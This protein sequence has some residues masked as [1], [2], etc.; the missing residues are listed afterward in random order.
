MKRSFF[1]ESFKQDAPR[2]NRQGAK[3]GGLAEVIHALSVS[4][5]PAPM[6]LQ[7][8]LPST[9]LKPSREFPERGSMIRQPPSM[10]IYRVL[11]HPRLMCKHRKDGPTNKKEHPRELI[12]NALSR[13]EVVREGELNFHHAIE[14]PIPPGS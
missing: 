4:R 12:Q 3:V 7:A 14:N 13:V 5:V 8:L 6:M 11:H 1:N 2:L 9:R 10:E